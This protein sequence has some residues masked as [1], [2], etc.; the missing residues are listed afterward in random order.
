MTN[1]EKEALFAEF[2]ERMYKTKKKQGYAS[3]YE[4]MNNLK[5]AYMYFR[6]RY[7]DV[8]EDY[9]F[10]IW[11]PYGMQYSSDWD[12]IRK[13]VCHAYGVCI[14]KNIPSEKLDEANQLAK[15]IIDLLFDINRKE[16]N[17]KL[18]ESD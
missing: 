1:E 9:E 17:E 10:D 18:R 4:T 8:M 3:A 2:E 13:L 5:P 7:Q 12:M 11:S 16:L 14:V 6:K 15:S